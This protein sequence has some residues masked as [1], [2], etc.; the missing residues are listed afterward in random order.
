MV[1]KTLGVTVDEMWADIETDFQADQPPP[2]SEGW[3]TI[4]KLAEMMDITQ[5][6]ARAFL[7]KMSRTGEYE[8]ITRQ[9]TRY[10]RKV[11]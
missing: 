6:R 4:S 11:K 8:M 9:N 1:D 5:G 3:F 2:A 10:Y 7:E